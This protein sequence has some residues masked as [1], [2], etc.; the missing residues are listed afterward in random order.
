[1]Q[2]RER[3]WSIHIHNTSDRF[4]PKSL[5][6]EK[7]SRIP[8]R[9]TVNKFLKG[10][11]LLGHFRAL[12]LWLT[13]TDLVTDGQPI[14]VRIKNRLHVVQNFKKTA[15]L[16]NLINITPINTDNN[17][18]NIQVDKTNN[19]LSI[20]RPELAPSFLLS[21]VISLVPKIDEIRVLT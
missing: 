19:S 13:S 14:S 6:L 16:N 11:S 17:L 21:N 15:N 5:R 20:Q 8:G 4:R 2:T 1:M 18:L 3:V 10:K 12:P 7:C 9:I